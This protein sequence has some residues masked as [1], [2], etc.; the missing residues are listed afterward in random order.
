MTKTG[1]IVRAAGGLVC[2]RC[3]DGA[4][5][6]VL[7][8]RPAYDDWSFPKGKLLRGES[9]PDAA[10]REVEEET[11]LRCRLTREVGI[12]AYR[13]SRGRSKTVR[14]WEMDPV[15]GVLAPANEIDD[16]RWVALGDAA[17]ELTYARDRE[18]LLGSPVANVGPVPSP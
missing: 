5:E 9:E 14:Y 2:R 12:I 3:Q 17:G 1:E 16:A 4:I 8:H 15:G 7:V 18:L 6:I 11:G 13:D 10:L